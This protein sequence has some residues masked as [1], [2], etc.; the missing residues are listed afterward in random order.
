MG[1]TI[2]M[3]KFLKQLSEYKPVD[4]C[5]S[6]SRDEVKLGFIQGL[7]HILNGGE[8]IDLFEEVDLCLEAEQDDM[9]EGFIHALHHIKRYIE[10]TTQGLY[11]FDMLGDEVG[12]E[13]L[14]KLYETINNEINET[15]NE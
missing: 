11:I 3:S 13:F 6:L 10:N 5:N 15:D 9:A 14:R 12:N 2:N 1:N 7:Q 8:I 4:T